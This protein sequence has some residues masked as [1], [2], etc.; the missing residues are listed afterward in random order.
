MRA[1]GMGFMWNGSYI[2]LNEMGPSKGPFVLKPT[3]LGQPRLNSRGAV[4]SFPLFKR[5]VPRSASTESL[6]EAPH[7][8]VES[9]IHRQN[10][11]FLDKTTVITYHYACISESYIRDLEGRP[12]QK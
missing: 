4:L 7:P 8:K 11:S 2:A 10:R 6:S 1:L 5:L 9:S 3:L 12:T